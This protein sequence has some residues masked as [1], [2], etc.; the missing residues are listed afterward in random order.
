MKILVVEDD[1]ETAAFLSESLGDAGHTVTVASDG[2]EGLEFGLKREHDVFII[3][4]MLPR[5]DGLTLVKTLRGAAVNVPTLFLTA[6]AGL[7]DR[8]A[9]LTAGGDDYLAKPFALSELLARVDA[10]ARR[11]TA[12]KETTTI[13]VGSLELDLSRQFATREGKKIPLK[14]LELRL[15]SY[16][17]MHAPSVV[18]RTM[19]LE[20]VWDFRFNPQTNIVDTHICRLRAKI[21]RGFSTGLIE[22]VRCAGYKLNA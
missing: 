20:A 5:L 7:D 19:L 3:D 9:G 8:V 11:P 22:T 21:D 15:L 1:V 10:V 4:R 16:L 17:M 12:T 2:A 18:T 6:V 13:R 14:P